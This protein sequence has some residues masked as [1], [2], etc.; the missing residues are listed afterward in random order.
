MKLKNYIKSIIL[1]IFFKSNFLLNRLHA[2][3]DLLNFIEKF[4]NHRKEK[5]PKKTN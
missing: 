2:D 1:K 4:K 5:I 3:H